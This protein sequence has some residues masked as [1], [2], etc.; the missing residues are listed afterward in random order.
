MNTVKKRD[1]VCILVYDDCQ[2]TSKS[3]KILGV[4]ATFD[5]ALIGGWKAVIQDAMQPWKLKFYKSRKRS[6]YRGLG[7]YTINEWNITSNERMATYSLGCKT[8]G[9]YIIDVFDKYLKEHNDN[10]DNIL[11]RWLEQMTSDEVVPQQLHEFTF[12]RY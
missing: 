6:P 11:Q 1:G 10:C 3:T 5:E 8:E 12:H 4:F 7:S 2:H 9:A